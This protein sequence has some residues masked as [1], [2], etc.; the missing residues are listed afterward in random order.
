VRIHGTATTEPKGIAG[1]KA[2]DGV[3]EASWDIPNV[4]FTSQKVTRKFAGVRKE[5]DL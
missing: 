3:V 1:H 5:S 4:K 2:W